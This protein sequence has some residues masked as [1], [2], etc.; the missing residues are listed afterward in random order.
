VRTDCCYCWGTM[1][2]G[3][4]ADGISHGI[5]KGCIPRVA[6]DYGLTE[7]ETNEMLR[8]A[9]PIIDGEVLGRVEPRSEAELL[10][11]LEVREAMILDG[12]LLPEGEIDD[13]ELPQAARRMW[14]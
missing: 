14:S 1:R 6:K 5:C 9:L 3:S 10:E 8:N 7:E 4:T 13:A 2:E 11:R 12:E